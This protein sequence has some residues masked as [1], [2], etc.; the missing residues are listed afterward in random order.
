[1]FRQAALGVAL[2]VAAIACTL[3]WIALTFDWP[4]PVVL[5]GWLGW[6]YPLLMVITL[7]L[8][9]SLWIWGGILVSMPADTRRG[10]AFSRFAAREGIWYMRTGIPPARL[11]VFFAEKLPGMRDRA[12]RRPP[13]G[14]KPEPSL[15]RSNFVLWRGRDA[16]EPELQLGIASYT[17]G[18]SDPKGPRNAFRFL[19]LRLPRA[20]PHLMIDARGNG[21]MRAALP[22]AQRLSLEGD[23]GKFFTVYVPAGYERDALELLTPDVMACLIDHG[24]SW[25][26]EVV[27]D[28]LQL[29][30]TK[31]L[32]RWDRSE[33]TALL[34]F[35]EIVSAE[36]GHQAQTYSDPRSVR[37]RAQVAAQGRRL[38]GRSAAWSTAVFVLVI[39]GMVAFPHVLGWFL[40]R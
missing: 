8:S 1:M 35:S 5:P 29:A 37:P 20:L 4:G 19:S 33:S 9:V 30:S 28:R 23:F 24:R 36:L 25:D 10:L 40:D 3:F 12:R 21:S 13:V 15:F 14:A 38:R 27:D 11:G 16:L 26:I 6:S 39:A 2:L 18:K 7:L 22:G 34:L 17:G 32:G 31:L